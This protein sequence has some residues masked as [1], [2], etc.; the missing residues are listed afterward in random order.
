MLIDIVRFKVRLFSKK[1]K[2]S[3]II[4]MIE[5]KIERPLN[6]Q[7][8]TALMQ[9]CNEPKNEQSDIKILIKKK[10]SKITQINQK[11]SYE[12]IITR[13]KKSNKL[14]W[15]I[16]FV[17]SVC[18]FSF[19]IFKSVKNYLKYDVITKIANIHEIPI[20]FPTISICNI[21]PFVTKCI[22]IHL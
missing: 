11:N 6:Q 13:R 12:T 16:F 10:M 22:K 4:K 1:K 3:H 20:P 5:L 14:V 17:I 7:E 2:Y 19:M 18:L 8:S 21:D 15:S 9:N